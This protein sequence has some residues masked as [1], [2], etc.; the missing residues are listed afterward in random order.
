MANLSSLGY[1]SITT[2]SYD[3]G[4][5]LILNIRENR[6]KV[7]PKSTTKTKSLSTKVKKEKIPDVTSDQA[8]R[9]LEMLT[10]KLGD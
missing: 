6:R 9:L 5:Q 10:N 1:K 8:A 2:L 4:L 7:K 3:E